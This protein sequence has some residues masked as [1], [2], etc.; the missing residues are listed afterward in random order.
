MLFNF[1][2]LIIFKIIYSEDKENST[3]KIGLAFPFKDTFWGTYE[4]KFKE[5]DKLFKDEGITF[6]FISRFSQQSISIQQADVEY[7]LS[8]KINVL[9]IVPH[10]AKASKTIKK[11]CDLA[12]IKIIAFNR[13]ISDVE[14]DAYVS[15][16]LIR[17][18]ELQAEFIVKNYNNTTTK[19]LL[20]M[21][22]PDSDKNSMLFYN[23]SINYLKNS[24]LDFNITYLNLTKW[25][26]YEAADFCKSIREKNITISFIIAGNDDIGK[27]CIEELNKTQYDNVIYMAGHDNAPEEVKILFEKMKDKFITIDMNQDLSIFETLV[28]AKNIANN[29]PFE[30]NTTI[31]NGNYEVPHIIVDVIEITYD[32]YKK[33]KTQNN[34][35][36]TDL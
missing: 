18:G 23:G 34:N 28:V 1:I 13:I 16:N 24:N 26:K 19:N 31:L 8:Q 32:D 17:V 25:D 35:I 30:F 3:I 33:N 7:L 14:I 4:E 21:R 9:V 22:G 11:Y 10:D 2:C 29:K 5:N 12:N 6:E 27:S 20:L 15:P 36:K